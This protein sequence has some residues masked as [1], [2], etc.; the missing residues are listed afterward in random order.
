MIKLRIDVDYAYPSRLVS[1][2]FMV[3]NIEKAKRYLENSKIIAKMINESHEEV[4]AYWFFTPKTMP[5]KELLELLNQKKHEIALH[6]ANDPYAELKLLEEATNR[7]LK[8]YTVH[9]TAR[10]LARLIWRRKLWEDKAEVP[11]NFPLK[12]FYDFPTLGLD[13]LCYA[14]TN[15]KAVRIAEDAIA[16]GEVL[17]I[18][19]IWL[20]QQ[21][22]I[23]RRGS[24]FDTLKAILKLPS[25]SKTY[26]PHGRLAGP[27]LR[28]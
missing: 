20:F 13:T 3:L 12:S 4:K 5:D 11:K 27:H 16:R 14:N 18:H 7:K 24:Y 10:V 19:P 1:F 6:V 23:N 9:G 2:L 17:H 28:S 15:E 21:G 26:K 22:T 25:F 8:Y